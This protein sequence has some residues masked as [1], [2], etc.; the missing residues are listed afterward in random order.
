MNRRTLLRN[1][2]T[3]TALALAGC[4]GDGQP[5]VDPTPTDGTPRE[6]TETTSPPT[7]EIADFSFAVT[8]RTS[9][10]TE[11][12]ATVSFDAT[13]GLVRVTSTIQG[14]DGCKT[15]TLRAI[16]YH[17]DADEVHVGVAT[18]DRPG[19]DDRAC[20]EALVYISYEATVS[21]TGGVPSAASVSHDGTEV[22]SGARD[23]ASAGDG[24]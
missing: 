2:A 15:A 16:D 12:T 8:D 6:G 7:I 17:R 1:G 11:P 22:T 19:T 13:E 18:T 10:T 14:S 24:S 9:E 20:T 4:S 21:F 23:S 3:L 5:G